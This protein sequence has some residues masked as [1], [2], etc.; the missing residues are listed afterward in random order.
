MADDTARRPTAAK[1]NAFTTLVAPEDQA[2][3]HRQTRR[4]R[5]TEIAEDY[6]ELIAELI[7]SDG[8]ARAVEI[9][10][11]LGVTPASVA[12]MLGRLQQMGLVSTRPYRAVFL[13]DEGRRI[14][15]KSKRR[16]QIVFEFLRAIGVSEE[17]ARADAE[18]IEHHVSAETLAAF[19]RIARERG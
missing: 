17:T 19:E 10:R 1:A 15:D 16:H 14:A 2:S 13:T 4:A 7:D 3:H 9:A 5:Q 6:V 11:R 12:K 8:E 18:G